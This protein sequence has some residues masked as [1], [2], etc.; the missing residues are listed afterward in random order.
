[1]KNRY[2]L[3]TGIFCLS[4][5]TATAQRYN[6]RRAQC[7]N[8]ENRNCRIDNLSDE[9]ESKINQERI[10]FQKSVQQQH[11]RLGELRAQKR[12]IETTTPLNKEALNKVLTEINS[13]NTNIQKKRVRHHQT[14]KSF[15]N[16]EQ[17]IAFDSRRQRQDAGCYYG[18]GMRSGAGK[19]H[20]M[21]PGKGRRGSGNGMNGSGYGQQGKAYQQGRGNGDGWR[22]Q[23]TPMVSDEVREN[24]RA[25]H[26]SMMK[27][28]QPLNNRLNELKAQQRTLTSG[29]TVD[30]KKVDKNIDEQAAIKLKIAKLH[31]AKR[32]EMRAQLGDEEQ[33]MFDRHRGQ[34]AHHREMRW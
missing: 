10:S 13:I 4:I 33:L 12:S 3:L 16:E 23:G 34:H 18:E 20:G 2:L 9:Q 1:M 7:A 22:Q 5:L 29:E 17:G 21:R 14:I 8:F 32:S 25:L 15:L 31:A 6:G 30:L 26:L 28:T 19:G 11:N 24:L 27:E